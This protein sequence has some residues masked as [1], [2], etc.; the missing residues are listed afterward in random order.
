MKSKWGKY[1]YTYIYIFAWVAKKNLEKEKN[2]SL[3]DSSGMTD[4]TELN[5]YY[6]YIIRNSNAKI[7][8]VHNT[9]LSIYL[10]KTILNMVFKKQICFNK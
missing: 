3:E 7:I 6:Y 4:E 5:Y 2:H 8:F 9:T 1:P 10:Q